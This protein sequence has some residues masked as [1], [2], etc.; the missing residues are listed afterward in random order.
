[1]IRQQ[2]LDGG[3]VADRIEIRVLA[4][5]RA[6]LLGELDRLPEMLDRI[7]LFAVRLSRQARL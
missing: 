7:C 4:R 2:L 3:I 6:E 1:L 5:V